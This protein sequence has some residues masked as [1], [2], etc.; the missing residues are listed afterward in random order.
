M[1][2]RAGAAIAA[3]W[4]M[5][6]PWVLDFAPPAA[7]AATKVPAAQGRLSVDVWT[8]KEEGGIYRSGERMQVFFRSSHDAYV[9]IYNIDTEGYI[10]LIYPFRPGD[11]VRIEGG[12]TFR[13]PARHDPYDLVAEG[14]EGVEY[15]VA[16]ASP[17]PLQD[18]PW[19]LA[20]GLAEEPR[21]AYQEGDDLDDGV[22]VGDP[23][24]GMERLH[25]RLVPDGREGQ[26]ASAD[27]YFYIERRVEYPRYVCA[28]CH[29]RTYWFDPY[30]DHCSVI[31]IR[32]DATWARYAPL[33]VRS[34][35]PRYYYN[36]RSTAPDRYRAWKDRWSSLDGP[37][38]LRSK[39]VLERE[40]RSRDVTPRRQSP[41]EF[42][43]LRRHRPGRLWQGR[44]E[45]IRLREERRDRAKDEVKDRL[46]ENR[47][48]RED[49]QRRRDEAKQRRDELKERRDD[50]KEPRGRRDEQI[51]PR[52][53]REREESEK[54]RVRESEPKPKRDDGEIRK[55]EE[56]R[57][58][59]GSSE[60]RRSNEER[61]SRERREDPGDRGQNRRR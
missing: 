47:E 8:N 31:E 48:R 16:I 17:L 32:I 3:A 35:R 52:T 51:A 28:D 43:D 45:V 36:V 22:I 58:E 38:S 14:P 20:P 26:V 19:F 12:E 5:A 13:V 54:P 11:P 1:K 24:V 10:H 56:K 40:R 25:R 21:D 49:V 37:A 41:Q 29:Y 59:R 39:F 33:R 55:R 27:T 46:Q 9:L 7:A 42:K 44:D 53:K 4:L 2:T 50:A 34:A 57:E 18:L 61:G 6:A 30:I 23:Y 60:E 15:V